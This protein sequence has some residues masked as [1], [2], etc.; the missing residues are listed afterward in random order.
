MTDS[1]RHGNVTHLAVAEDILNGV[2]TLLMEA[3]KTTQ[4]L[5]IEPYRSR[6][7]E[8]FVTAD[9]AQL[10]RDDRTSSISDEVDN[11]ADLSADGICRTLARRWGLDMAAR[12]ST[13][14]QSRLEPDQL[15]QMRLLWS[16]MRM[17]M[18]W[19]YAWRRWNEFHQK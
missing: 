15:E 7:F 9:G 14:S 10:V 6:L 5:E 13:A 18:E 2:E 3:R 12:E 1:D 17:W 11:P 19:A 16:V 8:L 4:P